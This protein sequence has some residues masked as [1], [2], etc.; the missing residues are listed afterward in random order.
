MN[1]H[2]LPRNYL[3]F[4]AAGKKWP[5]SLINVAPDKS[6]MAHEKTTHSIIFGQHIFALTN[7]SKI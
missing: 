2:A 6:T 1:F 5:I 7:K 4:L 3:Q